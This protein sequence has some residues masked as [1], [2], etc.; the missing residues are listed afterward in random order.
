MAINSK[1]KVPEFSIE[2]EQ[3]EFAASTEREKIK[4]SKNLNVPPLRLS[5]IHI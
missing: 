5:L 4:G 1:N 3:N 2:Q